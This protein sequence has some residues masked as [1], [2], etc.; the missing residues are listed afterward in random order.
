MSALLEA[1][2]AQLKPDLRLNVEVPEW[3]DD[4]GP[5]VVWF[6]KPSLADISAARTVA[7][8][9]P[10]RLNLELVVMMASDAAGKAL[11]ERT[12]AI[13]LMRMPGAA[14]GV[15]RIAA[16]MGL[17]GDAAAMADAAKN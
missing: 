2:R 9:D 8:D 1:L 6:K 12:D 7:K 10:V 15:G 14:A 11:F 13:E 4:K 17:V 3:G 5:L 16:A